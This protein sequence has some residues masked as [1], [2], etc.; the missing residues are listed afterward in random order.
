MKRFYHKTR[1]GAHEYIIVA[2]AQN[3][4]HAKD[5]EVTLKSN[6]IPAVLKND[7]ESSTENPGFAVMVPKDRLEEA[8]IVIESKDAEDDFYDSL[9]EDEYEDDFDDDISD[10]FF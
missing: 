7:D 2:V 9:T 6:N 3:W 1:D 4:E 8:E 10:Y 5:Y